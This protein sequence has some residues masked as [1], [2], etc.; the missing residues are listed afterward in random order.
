MTCHFSID[1]TDAGLGSGNLYS[2]IQITHDAQ[3]LGSFWIRQT[4][5]MIS[6]LTLDCCKPNITCPK[7]DAGLQ[8]H[9]AKLILTNRN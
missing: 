8:I 2:L 7:L 6:V 5:L 9:H 4:N 3:I 1:R